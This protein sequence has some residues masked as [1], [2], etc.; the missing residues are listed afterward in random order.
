MEKRLGEGSRTFVLVAVVLLAAFIA[1]SFVQDPSLTGQALQIDGNSETARANNP[2]NAIPIIPSD[3]GGGIIGQEDDDRD[4]PNCP[5]F[6]L[7]DVCNSDVSGTFSSE[8][9]AI[10]AALQSCKDNCDAKISAVYPSNS[11]QCN[12]YCQSN[13]FVG[14]L[15][16]GQ[17]SYE[18]NKKSFDRNHDPYG[19]SSVGK[20]A[21]RVKE[22]PIDDFINDITGGAQYTAPTISGNINVNCKCEESV[23]YGPGKI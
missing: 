1:G 19:C 6:L 12:L 8:S 10:N 22:G 3:F 13:S 4:P 14:P 17:E 7:N 23:I 2:E 16:P 18:C 5:D 11:L 21:K 20:K 15:Q 9:D